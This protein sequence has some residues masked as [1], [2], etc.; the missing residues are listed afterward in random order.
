MCPKCGSWVPGAVDTDFWL[1]LR[2]LNRDVS[3]AWCEN[4][5]QV[6]RKER[7]RMLAA[8]PKIGCATL[9]VNRIPLKRNQDL[10]SIVCDVCGITF[11]GQPGKKRCGPQCRQLAARECARRTNV[12]RSTGRPP[13]RPRKGK[14]ERP[15]RAGSLV[16]KNRVE[17]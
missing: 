5:K 10:I 11:E 14:H 16:L 2:A 12:R 6:H 9:A 7:E 1:I 4:C 13:G 8:E 3:W 15:V 17:A